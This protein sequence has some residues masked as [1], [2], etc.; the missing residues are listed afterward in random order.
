MRSLI[1]VGTL[2]LLCGNSVVRPSDIQ[3]HQRRQQQQQQDQHVL[4]ELASRIL[5]RKQNDLDQSKNQEKTM[6][7]PQDELLKSLTKRDNDRRETEEVS[8]KATLK[9]EILHALI[10]L[11]HDE[12][13]KQSSLEQQQK[14]QQQQRREVNQQR[15]ALHDVRNDA[16]KDTI[17]DEIMVQEA[18]NNAVAVAAKSQLED[19]KRPPRSAKRYGKNSKDLERR[20]IDDL[21]SRELI[22]GPPGLWG[23]DAI[24][25][26]RALGRHT[27]DDSKKRELI[28][29]PPGLWGRDMVDLKDELMRE[30]RDFFR[31]IEEEGKEE[32]KSKV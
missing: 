28:R 2:Y 24:D 16:S 26:P 23:R 22:R 11:L 21:M 29:G 32:R 5:N 17:A 4:D 10:K 3:Q 15:E 20:T 25:T 18:T 9:R 30:R 19:E 1:I 8:T 13:E 14:Q 6:Q 27:K 12:L 31:K 7:G